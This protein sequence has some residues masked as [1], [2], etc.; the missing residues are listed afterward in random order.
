M[1]FDDPDRSHRLA[2]W[3]SGGDYPAAL[4][5]DFFKSWGIQQPGKSQPSRAR[6]DWS[7]AEIDKKSIEWRGQAMLASDLTPQRASRISEIFAAGT[8]PTQ[9]SDVWSAPRSAKSFTV[10][11]NED[12]Y[13]L[14]VIE[15]GDNAVYRVQRDAAGESFVL[16]ELYGSTGETLYYTD[17]RAQPG[18]TYTYRVIPV[19]AEL[20]QNGILL[21]GQVAERAGRPGRHCPRR[22]VHGNGFGTAS[23]AASTQGGGNCP[24]H[25]HA[26]KARERSACLPKV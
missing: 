9:Y 1:G 20:L 5:R 13:P 23:L 26:L 8:Q 14:L 22:E 11:H 6:R 24:L 15:A 19:H 3:I 12:G 4:C 2:G 21:E 7:L 10:T 16:T 17:T 25:F 18:A